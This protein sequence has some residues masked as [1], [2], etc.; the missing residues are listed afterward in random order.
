MV[1]FLSSS[2]YGP[3]GVD[4]GSRSVKLMQLSAAGD[5]VVD[6]ARWDLPI[7]EPV[8]PERRDEL[9]VEALGRVREGRE[10]RGRRAALC[11]AAD[12][13]FVQNLRV[14]PAEGDELTKIV[15][16]E[17]A[18]RLPFPRE[19]ADLRYVEAMDVRHG[20]AVRREVI[21]MACRRQRIE[22]LLAIAERAELVPTAIDV[23][24]GALLR[25]YTR[26]YRRDD[27]QQQTRMY[28]NV[29]SR[30]TV[31]LIARASHAM[32]VKYIGCGA[33]D[34]DRA[35][36]SYLKIPVDDAVNLRRHN[37]DRR[38]DQRDPEVTRSIVEAVRPVLEQ[39]A[40]EL[41]LCVRYYSVTFRGQSVATT[42]LGGGEA[43]ETLAE[44]L[45]ARLTM[46]C[47]LG[48]PLR[49][50]QSIT[51]PGRSGQWDVAAGLALREAPLT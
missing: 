44:W 11:L 10:F 7:D 18:G 40:A 51:L 36:A 38:S 5:R 30:H 16:F 23:E 43:N 13:L 28:V 4:L 19:E 49:A 22:R 6:A 14:A 21:L 9:I 46:P 31:V 15:H 24:P 34:M 47:E 26:Q 3:L 50:F 37:G 25:C 27:D 48:E 33:H 35:V 29:G 8:N 12:D 41:A 42:V 45:S 20:D 32:F 2:R 17:A 39:L 1:G